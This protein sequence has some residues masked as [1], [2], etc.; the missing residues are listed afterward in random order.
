MGT[1]GDLTDKYY[2]K[3]LHFF[4]LSYIITPPPPLF[5]KTWGGGLNKRKLGE[6]GNY[7]ITKKSTV[8]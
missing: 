1:S 5:H 7:P 8:V 3:G 6:G 2:K 4:I